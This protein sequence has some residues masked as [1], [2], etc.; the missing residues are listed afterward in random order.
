M[1]VGRIRGTCEDRL[2][3]FKLQTGE[4]GSGGRLVMFH[5]LALL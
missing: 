2:L 3:A 4:T 5:P 1:R